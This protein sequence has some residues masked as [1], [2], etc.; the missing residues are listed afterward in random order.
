MNPL[1]APADVALNFQIFTAA[2]LHCMHGHARDR[3]YTVR[4]IT[5]DKLFMIVCVHGAFIT[6]QPYKQGLTMPL[7][8]EFRSAY[9][10]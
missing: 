5:A 2:V 1:I 9:T 4:P 6:S 3:S 8:H 7:Q 10:V